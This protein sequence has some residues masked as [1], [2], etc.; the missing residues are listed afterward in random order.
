MNSYKFYGCQRPEQRRI[1]WSDAFCDHCQH[2]HRS[3]ALHRDLYNKT[4]IIKMSVRFRAKT[5]CW[6]CTSYCFKRYT[7]RTDWNFYD[8]FTLNYGVWGKLCS[9]HNLYTRV[10][11]IVYLRCRHLWLIARTK[12]KISPMN[13]KLIIILWKFY[14]TT[15]I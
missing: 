2:K 14:E 7:L 13:C 1:V 5:G 3:P 12:T 11:V 8:N 4:Y 9:V 10:N 15:D 6:S